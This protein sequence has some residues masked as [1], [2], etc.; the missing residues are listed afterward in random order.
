MWQEFDPGR[1]AGVSKART[2]GREHGV[3]YRDF[4]TPRLSG[5]AGGTHARAFLV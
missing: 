4:T 5:D 1:A 3:V 2:S